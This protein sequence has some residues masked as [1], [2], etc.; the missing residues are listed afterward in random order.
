MNARLDEYAWKV[1]PSSSSTEKQVYVDTRD[2]IVEAVP[3]STNSSRPREYVCV[4]ASILRN[5]ANK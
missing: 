5:K 1:E 4:R 3:G 2:R